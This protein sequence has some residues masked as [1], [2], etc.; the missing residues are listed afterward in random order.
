MNL[1]QK[2]KKA[3]H[4]KEDEDDDLGGNMAALEE[5]GEVGRPDWMESASSDDGKL[6]DNRNNF[7]LGRPPSPSVD[8]EE[9]EEVME[10]KPS[11]KTIDR[12]GSKYFRESNNIN[13]AEIISDDDDDEDFE[14]DLKAAQQQMKQKAAKIA[15]PVNNEFGEENMK[16]SGIVNQV[17]LAHQKYNT[18]ENMIGG[19]ENSARKKKK[20][21]KKKN[22]INN[23]AVVEGDNYD[24]NINGNAPQADPGDDEFDQDYL[25]P[26]QEKA[27]KKKKKGKN[28]G[29]TMI[30]DPLAADLAQ[31]AH[32]NLY[33]QARQNAEELK[34]GIAEA[35]EDDS[36]LESKLNRLKDQ[37]DDDIGSSVMRG[38]V[39]A[40]HPEQ[41][42]PGVESHHAER[43]QPVAN[44]QASQ[45]AVPQDDGEA[46]LK[47]TFPD[48]DDDQIKTFYEMTGK[49]VHKAKQ[50]INQQLGIF[51]EE[52][53]DQLQGVDPN[54][55][56]FNLL[57]GQ[58][59][60]NAITE[61][62]RKMI[63]QAI[64]DSEGPR[65]V[66]PQGVHAV[67][68]RQMAQHA[69]NAQAQ[70][71][72]L[73]DPAQYVEGDSTSSRKDKIKNA[74]RNEKVKKEGN[75]C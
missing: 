53:Q 11:P 51:T 39:V 67:N 19:A 57:A 47:A 7:D 13:A 58:M 50:I 29:K 52:D 71:Q 75:Q 70:A 45:S 21:K 72:K 54:D 20:K 43:P 24:L 15:N 55:V 48:L 31:E 74:K 68:R 3:K 59:D 6:M 61:E 8:S 32:H 41:M 18:S 26:S 44:A 35:S 62:E 25:N 2:K 37:S 4:F 17:A 40:T 38:P 10:R 9:E 12:T 69:Q 23:T 27:K 73:A 33:D 64:R 28:I 16:E 1:L 63:E 49:D 34:N 66:V 46:I 56:E 42:N 36:D 5:M 22:I 65:N 14:A 30:N 60:P